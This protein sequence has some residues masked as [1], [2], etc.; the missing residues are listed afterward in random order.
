M[1]P[2][3]LTALLLSAL[4]VAMAAATAWIGGEDRPATVATGLELI[5][6]RGGP[7]GPALAVD[8]AVGDLVYPI[9]LWRPASTE[10]T[11]GRIEESRHDDRMLEI[12]GWAGDVSMGLRMSHVLLVAC[13]RVIATVAVEGEREDIRERHPNLPDAGWHARIALAD[14]RPCRDPVVTAFGVARFGDVVFPLEGEVAAPRGAGRAPP[15]GATLVRSAEALRT[16]GDTRAPT[17]LVDL[18][19]DGAELRRC[20][21]ERCPVIGHLPAGRQ[22]VIILDHQAGWALVAM[23]DGNAGWA[24]DEQLLGN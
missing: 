13:D 18:G 20:G 22:R 7:D 14:L 9:W 15:P 10:T 4:V 1:S 17:R 21:L 19:G 6:G 11:V 5:A 23:A 24:R 16:P 3:R 2:I 12:G 8:S